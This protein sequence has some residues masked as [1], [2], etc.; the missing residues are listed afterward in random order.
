MNHPRGTADV[1]AAA[2]QVRVALRQLPAVAESWVAAEPAGSR[3]GI[4]AYVVPGRPTGH[5]SLLRALRTACRDLPQDLDLHVVRLSGLP[6]TS[7]GAVDADRL[8]DLPVIS[9]ETLREAESAAR[10]RGATT[11]RAVVTDAAA[12]RPE[13]LIVKAGAADAKRSEELAERAAAL[14]EGPAQQPDPQDPRTLPEALERA[15]ATGRGV[16]LAAGSGAGT[17]L[18]YAELL[19]RAARVAGGLRAAGLR[20][21]SPVMLPAGDSEDFLVAFWGCQVGGL[22]PVPCAPAPADASEAAAERLRGIWELLEQPAI[23]TS[24]VSMV[25][26]SLA[27][28]ARI[29][30]PREL[31]LGEPEKEAQARPDGV[32]VMLLTSG[33]T[34]MPKLVTQTHR[35]I[36]AMVTAARDTNALH[37]SDVSVNWFPL[38]HVVGLLMCHVRDVWLGCEQVHAATDTVLRDPL[39][40]IDLLSEHRA[41]LTWAPNFAFALIH[42]RAAELAGRSWDLSP[43]RSIINAGEM[44]VAEQVRSFLTLLAPFGLR[45]DAVQPAWGMSETCS[46]V[47]CA[48]DFTG[49]TTS[50]IGPV[51]VGGPFPG[52]S[53]RIVRADGSLASEDETGDLQVT[54]TMVTV[55]YHANDKA[56]AES[57]TED[58]WFRTGDRALLRG[59]ALTIVGRSKDIIRV[60]GISIPSTEIEAIVERSDGV[61]ESFTGAVAYRPDNAATE[62][63]AV[64]FAPRPGHE[65]TAVA[66]D[67]QRRMLDHYGFPPRHI[68][69]VQPAEIPKTSIG[70]IRR[71]DLAARL[72][73][74]DFDDR[75]G[76]SD[77]DAAANRSGLWPARPVWTVGQAGPAVPADGGAT[78]VL[79]A[80]AHTA[81]RLRTLLTTHGRTCSVGVL[82]GGATEVAPTVQGVRDFLAR[83]AGG[84]PSVDEVV[85]AVGGSARPVVDADD[86]I[87]RQAD[88][89]ESVL[90]IVR[91]L[92]AQ[93]PVRPIRL[94]VL[95]PCASPVVD[96]DTPDLVLAPLGGLI[97]SLDAELP[98]LRARVIDVETG[99]ESDAEV[100]LVTGARDTL[101]S[102]RAGVR[103]VSRV[104]GWD[105]DSA[106]GRTDPFRSGAAYLVAGGLGGVGFEICRH[107]LTSKDCSLIVLGRTALPQ[108][109]GER[110]GHGPADAR[111]RRLRELQRLGRVRYVH[112]DAGDEAAVRSAIEAAEAA[113]GLPVEGALHLAGEMDGVDAAAL[114]RGRV[115]AVLRSKVAP[116][117][118]LGRLMA[119][120]S[121]F[122]VAF[123]SVNALFGGAQ[124]AAYAAANAFLDAWAVHAAAQGVPAHVLSWS[125]WQSM[126]MS[127]GAGDDELVRSRGYRVLSTEEGL[128]A[129]D[130][131][132]RLPAAHTVIGIDPTNPFVLSRVNAP[133]MPLDRLEVSCHPLPTACGDLA[134]TDVLGRSLPVLAV[135]DPCAGAP[136]DSARPQTLAAIAGF[137]QDVLSTAEVSHGEGFFELGAQSLHL[138]RVQY[139]IEDRLKVRVEISDFFRYPTV[140]ALAARVDRLLGPVATDA[141]GHDEG[142]GHRRT[143]NDRFSRL[144]SA[145]G[146]GRA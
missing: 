45:E 110:A 135:A 11:A 82:G 61:L 35:A 6:R 112:A 122:V 58:G 27:E 71:A 137:W 32:A 13:G 109:P 3:T 77:R 92:I 117:W 106:T 140:A 12:P 133:V 113:W 25:P 130:A 125:R 93:R 14:S 29:L 96:T 124:V 10:Q 40:W 7:D 138:P 79:A 99:R 114:D 83:A 141:L 9:D 108:T 41:T 54:G 2:D 30:S 88:L 39:R 85:L 23:L 34:G 97:C 26:A 123:S 132:M 129:F 128:R 8:R 118:T 50:L 144:R 91:S 80:D 142:A 146:E 102:Y 127:S 81:E 119:E 28:R 84:R 67:V 86:L 36:F 74:G 87:D 4:V 69:A 19:D 60:N 1:E 95:A 70:K 51:G 38:D 63:I 115:H 121:G 134:V 48:R 126:G 31:A 20:P 116:A 17:R 90:L 21:G 111:L 78:A 16:V 139:M 44:V 43:L 57:F 37:A 145:R 72:H 22:V 100:E 107:L 66:R 94:S 47:T 49:T 98:W 62:G 131:A 101:V 5:A 59:G 73:A 65:A 76:R 105:P 103:R 143:T 33:S 136:A 24:D 18:T 68:I 120:R 64:F 42:A 56:N 89:V 104:T 55:G 53:M 52:L 46:V 15:A 75:L